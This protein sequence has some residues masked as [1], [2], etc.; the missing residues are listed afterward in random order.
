MGAALFCALAGVFGE[1]LV[2][3]LLFLIGIDVTNQN[4]DL[5]E[6]SD[7]HRDLPKQF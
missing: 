3:A 4:G 5:A 2:S 1:A 6:S 7:V